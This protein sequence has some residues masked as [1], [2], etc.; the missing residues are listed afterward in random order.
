MKKSIVLL[1][2]LFVALLGYSQAMEGS[3]T[4]LKKQQPAAVI[5]LPYAPSVVNDAMKDYLSKKGRAKG[6]DIKGFTTFRIPNPYRAT[7]VMPTSILK[8][9]AKAGWKKR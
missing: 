4:Y 1:T 2:L 7:A 5:E 3:V 9:N 8:P 6:N